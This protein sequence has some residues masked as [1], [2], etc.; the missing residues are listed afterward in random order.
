MMGY[1]EGKIL[2]MAPAAESKIRLDD[3]GYAVVW[4]A[5]YESSNH[6]FMSLGETQADAVSALCYGL[7]NHGKQNGEEVFWWCSDDIRAY[8]LPLSQCVRDREVI[9]V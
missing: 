7:C 8:R 6:S 1:E 9:R 2:N 3:R 4:V 5:E